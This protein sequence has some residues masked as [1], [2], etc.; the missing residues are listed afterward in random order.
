PLFGGRPLSRRRRAFVA[1]AAHAA[2]DVRARLLRRAAPGRAAPPATAGY[3][4][5]H[6]RD[7]GRGEQVLQVAPAP[8]CP[9]RDGRVATLPR[10]PPQGRCSIASTKPTLLE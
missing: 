3:P 1:Q 8:A 9:E 6:S 4:R 7:R 2:S 5:L 10:P